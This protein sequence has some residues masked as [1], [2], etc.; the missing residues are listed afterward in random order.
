M[1]IKS[2]SASKPVVPAPNNSTSPILCAH[3]TSVQRQDFPLKFSITHSK[4]IHAERRKAIL[5]KYPEV[6]NLFGN[7]PRSGVFCLGTVL[8]QLSMAVA[9]RDM[10]TIPLLILTYVLS[11]TLNH[12]LLLAM[13]EVTHDL[14]FKSRRLNLAF[15][16]LANLPMGVPAASLFKIYHAEHHSGMGIDGIDTDI[17]TEA[18][19]WLFRTIPGRALWLIL[20]PLFYAV[21]PVILSPK[22]FTPLMFMASV[23]Q[24]SFD[25]CVAWFLG[26]NSFIYLIG[27]T[28]IGTGLHPMSGHFVAEH[29]EFILGQET[30]S[31]Y[32]PLN[33]LTYNV[34]Y[35]NEHHDFPR[36]PGSRLPIL[37]KMAPEFYNMPSYSSWTRVI[38]DFIIGRNMSLHGRVKRQEK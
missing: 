27:G 37:K 22:E 28:L 10:P 14:F 1:G 9:V 36:I 3:S 20:Q 19:A 8:I 2:K 34:G 5:E 32:G 23:V 26:W 24:F 6:R 25:F 35:H 11:G 15:A 38:Y 29:Y 7:D 18:E 33:W 31:Y 12:S 16:F 30:Y 13:H 17:P 21:R 4:E